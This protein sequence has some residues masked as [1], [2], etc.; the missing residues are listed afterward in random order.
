MKKELG[1]FILLV[2]LCAVTATLNPIFL[3]PTNLTNMAN[4]IGLFGVFEKFASDL[5]NVPAHY[6]GGLAIVSLRGEQPLAVWALDIGADGIHG[7]Y[8]VMNPAK[9]ARIGVPS[10]QRG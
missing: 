2:A 7:F 4:V 8:N 1:I 9:L 5:D 3:S 6:I 10:G